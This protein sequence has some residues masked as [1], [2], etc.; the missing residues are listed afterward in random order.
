M[1]TTILGI[2]LLLGGAALPATV[3]STYASPST[4][5]SLHTRDGFNGLARDSG[6]NLFLPVSSQQYLL[7]IAAGSKAA[8]VYLGRPGQSGAIDGTRAGSLLDGPMSV[9]ISPQDQLYVSQY[10]SVSMTGSVLLATPL[11]AVSVFAG[12]GGYGNG[13]D[14]GPAASAQVSEPTTVAVDADGT[15]Y[16]VDNVNVLEDKVRSIDASGVIRSVAGGGCETTG[17]DGKPALVTPLGRVGGLAVGGGKLYISNGAVIRQVDLAT[18]II[19]HYAGTGYAGYAGDGG[20]AATAQLS[21]FSMALDAQGDLY[22]D[23]Q[24]NFSIR[25][26]DAHGVIT[27]VA[28]NGQGGMSGLAEPSNVDPRSFAMNRPGAVLLDSSGNLYVLELADEVF[29]PAWGGWGDD[30]QV[31]YIDF[32]QAPPATALPSPVL[33]ATATATVTA[34]STV[35]STGP[36]PTPTATAMPSPVTGPTAAPTAGVVAPTALPTIAWGRLPGSV[37]QARALPNPNPKR[38]AFYSTGAVDH[39]SVEIYTANDVLAGRQSLSASEE[40]WHQ[41]ALP[42]GLPRGVLLLRVVQPQGGSLSVRSMHF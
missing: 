22:V 4:C 42:D 14:G 13:G 29:D 40:G 10:D 18:G 23:D 12:G 27:T 2:L 11:G 17:G 26:I 36:V 37:T 3:I 39:V 32:S 41:A 24:T 20:P 15:V 5:P 8:S 9:A 38:L 25:K 31:R 6:G 7:K 16:F 1:K 21:A 28:G 33:T 19:Q 35:T 30:W 34:T